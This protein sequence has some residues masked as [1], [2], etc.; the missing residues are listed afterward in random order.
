MFDFVL[1]MALELLTIFAKGSILD[2]WLGSRC[3]SDM[4]KER[5]KLPKTCKGVIF[6]NVAAKTKKHFL[7]NLWEKLD[8]EI[9][10]FTVIFSK[11]CEIFRSSHSRCSIKKAVLKNFAIFTG[12]HLCRLIKLKRHFNKG[13]F[14][15]ILRNF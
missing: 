7:R 12:K 3:T 14:L 10:F 5:Q 4:F 1:N 6:R 11:F 8:W 2:V 13:V 9:I 15:W